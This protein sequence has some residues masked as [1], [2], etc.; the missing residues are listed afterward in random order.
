MS[1][2]QPLI[3][4][5]VTHHLNPFRS[6]V[7]R[8]N[9]L[10]AQRLKVPLLGLR[11]RRVAVAACPLLS[12]KVSE[13]DRAS[14]DSLVSV[15]DGAKVRAWCLFLHEHADLPLE[16]RLVRGAMRVW[17]ANDE[18][19]ARISSLTESAEAAWAPGLISDTRRFDPAAISVFSFGMAHKIRTDMFERLKYLLEATGESY[20]IYLSNANHETATLEDA[21]VVFRDMHE[22]FPRGLYFAGNLSDVAVFNYLISTT[23]FAAFFEGG[24]RANNT[25]VASAMEHGAVVITNLDEHSP[26]YFGHLDNLIDIKQCGDA[27]PSDN[28]ILRRIGVRAIETARQLTWERL[29]ALITTSGR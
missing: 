13:L 20:A 6:G 17:C 24:V 12:L 28:L 5:I 1:H 4:A 10:L 27:L 8:F 29:T 25:S 11:D 15:L 23:F 16:D 18:V 7:A 19:L 22:L 21:E 3:D 14:T 9:E 2:D 26:S